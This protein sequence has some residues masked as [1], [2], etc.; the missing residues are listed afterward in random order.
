MTAL[1][2]DSQTDPTGKDPV[3]VNAIAEIPVNQIEGNP[4]QPREDYKEESLEE[5]VDSVKNHGI[6]QPVTVRKVGYEKYEIISGERRAKAAVRAGLETIPAF[7]RVANDQEM[8][9][10]ALIENIHRENLNAIEIA[11]SYQRLVDECSLRQEQVADRVGKKRA[12]VTNY[13]RLLKLPEPIQVALRDGVISM[14]HARTL[15]NIEDEEVQKEIFEEIL[16]KELSVRKTEERV[17]QKL[18][19]PGKKEKKHKKEETSPQF[20]QYQE[21]LK[22]YWPADVKV[23]ASKKGSGEVVMKFRSEEELQ[24]LIN[25]FKEE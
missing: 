12:T 22:S 23:K 9:E 24:K 14:G 6:I 15:I 17:Q 25:L 5:L 13:L 7:V 4:F 10:M 21:T 19:D 18:K 11:L 2:Q 3:P 16:K 8:V 20:K 1:L